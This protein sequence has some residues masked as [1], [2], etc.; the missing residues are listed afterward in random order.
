MFKISIDAMGGDKGPSAIVSGVEKFIKEYPDKAVEFHL[1]GDENILNQYQSVKGGRIKIYHCA[2]FISSD[3]D[4]IRA[5]KRKKDASMVRAFEFVKAGEAN[6]VISSGNTG[7]LMAAGLFIL[8][9]IP[10][11]ERPALSPLL[12][13]TEGKGALLIDAGANVSPKAEHLTQYAMMGAIYMKE[14]LGI[15]NPRVGLLNIGSEAQKGTELMKEVHSL[16]C[17]EPINFIGN[18]EARDVPFGIAEVIVSD[19]FSGNILLKSME[20]TAQAIFTQLKAALMKNMKTKLGTL[21]IKSSL[22]ELKKKLDY[23]EYG[24]APLLGLNYPCIKAHGSSNDIAFKNAIAQA[25]K[26]LEEDMVDKIRKAL[27]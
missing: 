3:D 10:G 27:V 23:T 4:P 11:I 25:V 2:E 15:E 16:L 18:I 22:K 6:A 1:F 8:G 17:K 12:P 26:C 21:L 24:G 20:G 7:A 9:R 14:I 5:I 19:G 13:T